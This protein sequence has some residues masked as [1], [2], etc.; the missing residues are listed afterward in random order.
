MSTGK[1][2]SADISGTQRAHW[3]TFISERN[4]DFHGHYC[5]W[6]PTNWNLIKKQRWIRAYRL[7]TDEAPHPFI[8]Q[9]NSYFDDDGNCMSSN[10]WDITEA[11][12]TPRGIIHPF[13]LR[14]RG[15]LGPVFLISPAPRALAWVDT[16]GAEL[17]ATSSGGE[18]RVSAGFRFDAATGALSALTAIREDAR[19]WAGPHWHGD[20]AA[21]APATGP[22]D[23]LRHLRIADASA[24]VGA[25]HARGRGLA[26]APLRGVGWAGHAAALD[27]AGHAALLLPDGVAVIGPRAIPAGRAPWSLA[28]IWAAPAAAAA[29]GPAASDS[30]AAPELHSLEVRYGAGGE[31]DC[32]RA[33]LFRAGPQPADRA[34]RAGALK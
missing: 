18:L 17:I 31:F 9:R 28:L 6:D 26:L 5:Q 22:A 13:T 33:L 21:A 19:G 30:G 34:R 12:S 16:A 8:R 25:G 15:V 29:A 27:C 4:A 14:S 3:Q 24:L 20:A 7:I 10:P 1:G 32:F 11:L 23:L 2:G